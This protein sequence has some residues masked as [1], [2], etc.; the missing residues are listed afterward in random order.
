MSKTSQVCPCSDFSK[1][2]ISVRHFLNCPEY[3]ISTPTGIAFDNR[4]E[5]LAGIPFLDVGL[6]NTTNIGR[7]PP[8]DL[9]VM[10]C[11][12]SLPCYTVLNA[13]K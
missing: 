3:P 7:I 4:S 9:V 2:V 11:G 13:D 1:P 5:D 12:C 6:K 10:G 8:S